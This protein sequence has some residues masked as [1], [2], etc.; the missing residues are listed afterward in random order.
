MNNNR[1]LY[2]KNC[3]RAF[4]FTVTPVLRCLKLQAEASV[5]EKYQSV[6]SNSN[7]S[8]NTERLHINTKYIFKSEPHERE[9]TH[10]QGLQYDYFGSDHIL[11]TE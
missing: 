8:H 4:L 5:K 1:K 7:S 6:S 9:V 2:M 11:K 3:G 10:V